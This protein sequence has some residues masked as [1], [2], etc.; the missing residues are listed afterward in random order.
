MVQNFICR[1]LEESSRFDEPIHYQSM[2]SIPCF[3]TENPS[4]MG[5]ANRTITYPPVI[6]GKPGKLI[7]GSSGVSAPDDPSK[8]TDI[9]DDPMRIGKGVPVG[10]LDGKSVIRPGNCLPALTAQDIF[11]LLRRLILSLF[12]EKGGFALWARLVRRIAEAIYN[13]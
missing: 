5:Q 6:A 9:K 8:A 4:Q 7:G 3:R 2:K 12:F 10:P 1:Y 11:F 13:T